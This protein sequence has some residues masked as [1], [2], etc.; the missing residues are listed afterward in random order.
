MSEDKIQF[1]ETE[2]MVFE[3]RVD[4]ANEEKAKAVERLNKI[5]AKE[6][7]RD[8]EFTAVAKEN[9]YLSEKVAELTETNQKIA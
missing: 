8:T 9:R 3:S 6:Q 1:L 5:E 7:Q 2:I 4:R